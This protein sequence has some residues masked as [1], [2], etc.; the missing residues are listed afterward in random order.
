MP[1]VVHNAL[2]PVAV[3]ALVDRG[4]PGR[5]AD[6]NGLYLHVTGPAQAKWSLRYMQAGRAREMGLG[7]A[8]RTDGGPPA[9]RASKMP[10]SLR[11]RRA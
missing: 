7:A 9:E 1:R 4:A 8:Q 2:T 10:G 6:G 11:R 5:H 3:R